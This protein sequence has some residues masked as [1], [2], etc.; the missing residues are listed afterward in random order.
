MYF[1]AQHVLGLCDRAGLQRGSRLQRV[2]NRPTTRATYPMALPTPTAATYRTNRDE[3]GNV[4]D[5]GRACAGST[6]AGSDH[7]VGGLER[8]LD[9]AQVDALVVRVDALAIALVAPLIR[10]QP[11]AV[12][13]H[14][15]HA[16]Q[17]SV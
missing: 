15:D 17:A 3:V 12:R 14:I 1:G 8:E 11:E 6:D 16:K 13:G 5:D 4:P 9:R 10:E 7:P 2:A